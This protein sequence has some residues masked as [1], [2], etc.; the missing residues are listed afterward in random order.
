MLLPTNNL[1]AYD[2]DPKN[3]NYL[4]YIVNTTLRDAVGDAS[5]DS[6]IFKEIEE[7]KRAPDQW[8]DLVLDLLDAY[9][10]ESR[11]DRFNSCDTQFSIKTCLDQPFE[12]GH[13][14]K[15]VGNSCNDRYCPRCSRSIN[16]RSSKESTKRFG[17]TGSLFI[18]YEFT[19]PSDYHDKISF[20]LGNHDT[21]AIYCGRCGA[22]TRIE[23]VY[24]PE[25]KITRKC[26]K[27]GWRGS[28]KQTIGG[29]FDLEESNIN[30]FFK[31]VRLTLEEYHKGYSGGLAVIHTFG[32]SSMNWYP[33]IHVLIT[34][35]VISCADWWDDPDRKVKDKPSIRDCIEHTKIRKIKKWAESEDLKRLHE[36]YRDQFNKE[37]GTS[38]PLLVCDRHYVK[39]DRLKH[40]LKYMLRIPSQFLYKDKSGRVYFDD[41]LQGYDRTH[42]DEVG[43]SEFMK[44]ARIRAEK[45][46]L[47][48]RCGEN[49]KQFNNYMDKM[50]EFYKT[51]FGRRYFDR[52]DLQFFYSMTMHYLKPNFKTARWFG[53]MSDNSLKAW[54]LKFNLSVLRQCKICN[55]VF[56]GSDKCPMCEGDFKL[57]FKDEERPTCKC[58][59]GLLYVGTK[60]LLGEWIHIRLEFEDIFK[61]IVSLVPK[62]KFRT[63]AD[64]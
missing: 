14:I 33:H 43:F 48:D 30:R 25:K 64:E 3:H 11:R 62:S 5:S 10:Q 46:G 13:S 55:H 12:E 51:G 17:A 23:P 29:Y 22:H 61:E 34:N 15:S 32:S 6:F 9:D 16:T 60:D 4:E 47:I 31:V 59:A 57:Y 45:I 38:Y 54:A 41:N 21:S 56:N 20:S 49:S 44:R 39:K 52:E 2:S 8:S 42:T 28:E 35:K 7:S 36:I 24:Y 18:S 40:R 50:T 53:W 27:C 26:V 58:G 1:Y 63:V 19:I 37:F